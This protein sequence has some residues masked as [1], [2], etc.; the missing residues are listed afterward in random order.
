MCLI[1]PFNCAYCQQA[2]LQPAQEFK[3]N[4][5]EP[6][7]KSDRILIL[8]PHPD[9]E[10][11]GCAGIIQQALK[12]GADIHVVYL[13][14]GDHNE[15]AFIVYKKELILTKAEFIQMGE[16]RKKEAIK[17]MKLLGLSETKLVFLG[18]PD[19][20]T[21]HIFKDYWQSKR[22]FRDFLTRISSV[23]YKGG[24][25]YGAPYKAENILEDLEKVLKLYRP[26]KIFVSHPA[27]VNVDHKAL[28]LFL[29]IA[30]ADLDWELPRPKIYPYLIHCAGWPLPRHYRPELSLSPPK[31]FLDSPIRWSEYKLG[32]EE[33][34]KKHQAIL[35][36]RSQ[37]ASS[38]FYLLAFARKNELFGDYPQI[39]LVLPDK[40]KETNKLAV[41]KKQFFSFFNLADK[42]TRLN[43]GIS[44]ELGKINYA[45]DDASLLIRIR[46]TKETADRRVIAAFYLFGYSYQTPFAQMPKLYIITKYKNFRAFDGKKEINP[47]GVVLDLSRKELIL[48]VP[49]Q[50]LGRPD[51]ILASLRAYTGALPED[52]SGFYKI[53][54]TRGE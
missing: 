15:F 38:A 49:L 16:L 48:K 9:D 1:L 2:P 33:L 21:F 4:S 40:T 11:I 22:P 31:K 19:F 36:Y 47:Q 28:Y 30:L 23:P 12:A 50:L 6:I 24:L 54:L 25:S 14:N 3:I 44:G 53:N 37:T 26:T 52:T 45:L 27:D 41:L 34:E 39:K 20:G 42:E 7:K 29:E 18:Y 32:P 43:E 5:L 46:K 51:F 10:T 8:A 35:C 17:A 13:T